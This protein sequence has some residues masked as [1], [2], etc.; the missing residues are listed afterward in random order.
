[1][2]HFTVLVIG[3][4]PEA[5]LAP[6]HEFECTG[7]VDEFVQSVDVTQH[8]RDKY[9]EHGKDQNFEEFVRSWFGLRPIKAG[10]TPD[11]HGDQ[12]YG[13]YEVNDKGGVVKVVRRTNP[14]A[15]WDWYVLGGRWTGFFKLKEGREGVV[16]EPGILTEPPPHGYVD[17]AFKGDIDFEAMRE[18]AAEGARK[19]YEEFEVALKGREPPPRFEEFRKNYEDVEEARK[20]YWELPVVKDLQ[21]AGKIPFF[22]DVN[23]IYGCGKEKFIERAR[24][25]AV[26]TFAFIKDGVWHEQGEMGWFGITKNEKDE[27]E[28][29]REFN[30][31]LD[32]LPDDTLLSV[33]DCH[34]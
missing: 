31:V 28:W 29:L 33:Y 26:T 20:A 27:D 21:K 3:E 5:Q 10:A 18:K 4:N 17:Q 23:D 6:Y 11:L 32:S 34:I 7:V 12:K 15:K 22:S 25:G 8:A 24:L 19:D 1:M 13:W 16:G 9:R 30:R 14:N 2:S